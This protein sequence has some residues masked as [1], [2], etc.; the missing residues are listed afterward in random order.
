MLKSG[1]FTFL[2][3]LFLKGFGQTPVSE[4]VE[5]TYPNPSKGGVRWIVSEKVQQID[6]KNR[7]LTT[8]TGYRIQIFIGPLD[9]AKKFR[10]D[11]IASHPGSLI[12]LS[13]NIPD[14][15]LRL[16]N[17]LSK[18]EAREALKEVRKEIP[19]AFIVDDMVEPPRI[20][21]KD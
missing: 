19:S 17:Y 20:D 1:F 4:K 11:Y 10:Q 13:Q 18:S 21:L 12:Y 14:H 16:G 5:P 3:F 2:T 9:D 15:V 6:Y 8:Q 7:K